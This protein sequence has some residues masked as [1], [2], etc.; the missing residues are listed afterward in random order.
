M[1]LYGAKTGPSVL[2]QVLNHAAI[3]IVTVGIAGVDNH[4][5]ATCVGWEP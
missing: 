4:A 1:S 3:G 2:I 5:E